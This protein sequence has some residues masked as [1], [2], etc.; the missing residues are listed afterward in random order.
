[1]VNYIKDNSCEHYADI[2]IFS[3]ITSI[4]LFYFI[5]I[6]F[7]LRKRERL[8]LYQKLKVRGEIIR[9]N[10]QKQ[11]RI[12]WQTT[13]ESSLT[14]GTD[15]LMADLLAVQ[16]YNKFDSSSGQIMLRNTAMSKN[17]SDVPVV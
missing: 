9:L 8:F 2:F 4:Y 14:D 1:M 15:R 12:Y 10:Q 5:I 13:G 11:Y 17:F 16:D 3:T 6:I 7:I